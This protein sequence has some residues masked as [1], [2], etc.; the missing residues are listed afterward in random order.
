MYGALVHDEEGNKYLLTRNGSVMVSADKNDIIGMFVRGYADDE[1]RPKIDSMNPHI[2]TMTDS[3]ETF[4]PYIAMSDGSEVPV[5]YGYV[6][7]AP[8]NE[9]VEELTQES[10]LETIKVGKVEDYPGSEEAQQSSIKEVLAAMGIDPDNV[11][12]VDL[13]K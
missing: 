7:A 3:P 1:T 12:E 9:K 10:I 13:N 8:L 4:R 2:L 6:E 11:I 5:I